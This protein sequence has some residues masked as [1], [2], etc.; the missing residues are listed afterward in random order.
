MGKI[1]KVYNWSRYPVVNAQTHTF[2]TREELKE[3]IHNIPRLI[4]RGAGLSYGDAS[5]GEHIL[6]TKYFNKILEFDPV[7]GIIRCESGVTLAELLQVI[8]PEGWFLPVT[9]GT[10]FITVGGA[11]AADVHGKNHHKEGSFGHYVQEMDIMVASGEVIT[12]SK[13]TN[14][15]L[16]HDTCGG[17]GL[18]GV[19]LDAAIQ[20][21][22]IETSYIIQKNL[23]APN[24]KELI[25]LL[26]KHNDSTYSVAWIDCISTGKA[27]GK[28]VLMVGEHAEMHELSGKQ[29][30]NPSKVHEYPRVKVPFELPAFV[31]SR[32][33]ISIFNR[34]YHLKHVMAKRELVS[35]YDTFFYPL[36]FVEGWNKMY[37]KRGFLQYQFVIPFE[38][39]EETLEEI[40][41]RISNSKLASFLSVLKLLGN[42]EHSVA[43]PMPGFTLALDLPVSEK[44]F[45]LLD[46]LDEIVASKGGRLYLAKDAR[47]K[48]KTFCQ[49][50]PDLA[51]F[52]QSLSRSGANKKFESL[53]SKRLMGNEI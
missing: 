32:F 41:H 36:D 18:T 7:K 6:S 21:K 52:R 43:F 22:K 42:G 19:V 3:L 24:L 5:L 49:G 10:K 25:H 20:L 4:T 51:K 38:Q 23:I 44:L 45:P 29:R 8:V 28:G 46:D 14:T 48:S 11:I 9:P 39:G 17:M 16:F 35:H 30:K 31:L 26:K 13:Q 27:M 12:C 40:I 53:L 37:G 15:G 1:S 33:S 34:L 47:M 2:R 50:Y